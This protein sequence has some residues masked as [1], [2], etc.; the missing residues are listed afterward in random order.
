M[1]MDIQ[2]VQK[3]MKTLLINKWP[4]LNR[5]EFVRLK[6]MCEDLIE[7]VDEKLNEADYINND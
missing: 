7:L 4:N 3:Q 2:D 1:T 5:I 6:K